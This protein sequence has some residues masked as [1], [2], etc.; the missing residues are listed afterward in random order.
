MSS[1]D[2]KLVDECYARESKRI[3]RTRFL[4]GAG[5]MLAGAAI[6]VAALLLQ[7]AMAAHRPPLLDI[8][9]DEDTCFAYGRLAASTELLETA[10]PENGDIDAD[11]LKHTADCSPATV[12]RGAIDV[13]LEPAAIETRRHWDEIQAT[14]SEK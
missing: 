11:F 7:G 12:A 9:P 13:L 10:Y 2:T 6:P 3:R 1:D 8:R 4:K 5:L 14:R